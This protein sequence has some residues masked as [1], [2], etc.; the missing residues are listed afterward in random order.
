VDQLSNEIAAVVLKKAKEKA[1][2]L[3]ISVN[4]AVVDNAGYLVLFERMDRALLGTI[5]I[6]IRKAKTAALFQKPCHILGD[7]SQ[8]GG[9]LYQIEHSN[10][11]M[12][13]FA[14]GLPVYNQSNVVIGAIGVSGSTIDDDLKV[15]M[16]GVS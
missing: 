13:T 1:H 12:I 10:G 2:M 3:A 9:P 6:A 11:G 4:I 15:A 8:P 16:A 14:G 5:D 7:K